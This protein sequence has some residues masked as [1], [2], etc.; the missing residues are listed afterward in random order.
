MGVIVICAFKPR[1]GKDAEFERFIRGHVP[2]LRS[3]GLATD[4]T[5]IAGRASDGSVIEVFEW[6]S[7]G[8]IDEAHRHPEVLKMWGEFERLCTYHSLREVEGTDGLFPNFAPIT[9]E[10]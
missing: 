5:A 8:A 10:G 3:L 9:L 1:P 2:K 6:K 4:R 7:K